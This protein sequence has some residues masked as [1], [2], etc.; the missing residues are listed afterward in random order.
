MDRKEKN[1]QIRKQH[2]KRRNNI[3]K[4]IFSTAIILILTKNK[5]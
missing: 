1:K 5:T 2:Q 3:F 4:K